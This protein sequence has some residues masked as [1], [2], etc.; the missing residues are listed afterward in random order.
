MTTPRAK[1]FYE[2]VKDK[3]DWSAQEAKL[4]QAI[5][6]MIAEATKKPTKKKK[7]ASDSKLPFSPGEIHRR[8]FAECNAFTN[9]ET[10]DSGSFGRLGRDLDRIRPKCTAEDVGYL[11]EWI[12]DGGIDHWCPLPTWKDA[13]RHMPNWIARAREWAGSRPPDEERRSSVR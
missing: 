4:L 2:L 7:A 6:V 12:K 5:A 9:F 3:A 13:C 11:V 10:Y 8:L 1:Q